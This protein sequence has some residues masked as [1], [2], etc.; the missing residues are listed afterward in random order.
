MIAKFYNNCKFV[1]VGEV[2]RSYLRRELTILELTDGEY[3]HYNGEKK[4]ARYMGL[5]LDQEPEFEYL[6]KT[7]VQPIYALYASTLKDKIRAY[8][9]CFD[10]EFFIYMDESISE[11]TSCL[12]IFLSCL[13]YL[14]KQVK[15][16]SW[17]C[18]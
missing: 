1:A 10:S 2:L 18:K 6:S 11:K 9:A 12:I 4:D 8:L 13:R 15:L 5:I 17:E 7:R 3:F 16:E 14:S